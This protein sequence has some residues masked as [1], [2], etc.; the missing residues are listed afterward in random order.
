MLSGL[1]LGLGIFAKTYPAILLPFALAFWI[2]FAPRLAGAR[3]RSAIACARFFS[4]V[5][6]VFLVFLPYL[7]YFAAVPGQQ[8]APE[9]FGGMTV[10]SLYNI[11]MAPLY[12][13]TT[14]WKTLVPA[15]LA[16]HALEAL[17]A[18]AVLAGILAVALA[19]RRH[20]EPTAAELTRLAVQATLAALAGALLSYATPE[21]EN[22]LAVLPIAAATLPLWPRLM[23]VLYAGLSAAGFGLYMALFTPFGAFVPV[24][25]WAGP[26]VIHSYT[27]FLS[28]YEAGGLVWPPPYYWFASGLLGGLL[29]LAMC[30]RAAWRPLT[31]AIRTGVNAGVRAL[32]DRP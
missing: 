4:G 17:A 7:G 21:P 18:L 14:A 6:V 19:R 20:A 5:G 8:I 1:A 30:A 31:D 16:L 10:L 29:L 15:E 26:G 22:V 2:V 3:H 25:V 24:M 11:Q 28:W 23:P 12:G 27:G 32:R 13:F 9:D